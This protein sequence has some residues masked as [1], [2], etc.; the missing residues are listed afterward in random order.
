ME[1]KIPFKRTAKAPKY[2]GINSIRN[3][4][5]LYERNVKTLLKNRKVD[6]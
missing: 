6:F 5:N 1:D 3:K 4:Q 2:L